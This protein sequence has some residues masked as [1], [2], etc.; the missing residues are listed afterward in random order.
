MNVL[1]KERTLLQEGKSLV[2]EHFPTFPVEV[3]AYLPNHLL[4][5]TVSSEVSY[6]Q[7]VT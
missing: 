7:G 1:I 5:K 6:E 4:R 2:Q 3:V